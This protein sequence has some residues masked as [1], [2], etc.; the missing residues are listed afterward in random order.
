MSDWLAVAPRVKVVHYEDL[1]NSNNIAKIIGDILRF[2]GLP[3]DER[4]LQCLQDS[5]VHLEKNEEISNLIFN[6]YRRAFF[7]MITWESVVSTNRNIWSEKARL[8]SPL[9]LNA[10]M[11]SSEKSICHD[12]KKKWLLCL[13]NCLDQLSCGQKNRTAYWHRITDKRFYFRSLTSNV[14]VRPS[15]SSANIWTVRSWMHS[16]EP[17][18]G[19]DNFSGTRG[20]LILP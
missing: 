16:T 11:R 20:N 18:R 10:K 2:L 12:V 4:R 15:K 3:G 1:K 13:H 17:L 6:L 14:L 5:E 8:Q 7:R 19:W 9:F